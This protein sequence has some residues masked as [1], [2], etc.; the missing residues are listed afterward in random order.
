M[1]CKLNHGNAEF[2]ELDNC[3]IVMQEN[4]IVLKKFT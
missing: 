1:D 4:V 3:T 2:P